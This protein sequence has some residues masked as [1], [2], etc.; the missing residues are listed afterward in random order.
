M[1]FRSKI[2]TFNINYAETHHR[3]RLGDRELSHE[4]YS[5]LE[6]FLILKSESSCNNLSTLFLYQGLKYH[7]E[8]DIVLLLGFFENFGEL[9]L[10]SERVTE[11]NKRDSMIHEA[12]KL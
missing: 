2:V 12:N 6:V 8:L 1:L 5:N 7:V 11:H 9:I 10:V 4:K 3:L